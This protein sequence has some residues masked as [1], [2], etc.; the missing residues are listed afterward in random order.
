ME[1]V[2]AVLGVSERRACR[3]LGQPRSTQRYAAIPLAD[4]DALTADIIRLAGQ[5]GRYSYRRI[6]AAMLRH[7][8]WRV[9]HK[10]V[11][12][13]WR[14]AGL[15]VPRKQPKRGRLWLNDDSCVR[16]RPTHRNHV[17]AY[18]FM[19]ARTH[20]GRPFRILTILD[21]HTRE[22]LAIKVARRIRSDDVLESLLDLFVERG[23]PDYIRADNRPEFTA[24]AVRDCSR[25]WA[26]KPCSSSRFVPGR[27]VTLRVSTASSATS[28]ST[29]R[30][31]T[32]SRRPR[33]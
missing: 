27:T 11:E 33:C 20:S 26:P 8:G 31:S 17:W 14:R 32:P 16:L 10:R 15:K 23:V 5:Y 13:I 18:D 1:H 2:I 4:E 28:Y 29:A 19:A 3:A 6:S 24:K 21:E 25:G 30:S 9:N 22:G 7:R 12:R